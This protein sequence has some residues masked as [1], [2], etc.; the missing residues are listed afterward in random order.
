MFVDHPGVPKKDFFSYN[1]QLS[2]KEPL[3]YSR[4]GSYTAKYKRLR[5]RVEDFDDQS[6]MEHLLA[7]LPPLCAR[8]IA[9]AEAADVRVRPVLEVTCHDPVSIAIMGVIHGGEISPAAT[10]TNLVDP[11]EPQSMRCRRR[12]GRG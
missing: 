10:R 7:Q 12:T 2:H 8:K 11:V 6:K 9:E 5:A 3:T 4:W 1:L